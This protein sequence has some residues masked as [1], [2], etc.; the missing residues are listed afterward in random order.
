PTYREIFSYTGLD[1][2]EYGDYLVKG[3]SLLLNDDGKFTDGAELAGVAPFGWYWA[4]PF[5]DYDNDGRLDIYAA[6]GWITG[7]SHDDL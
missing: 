1:W 4:S 7:K 5:F 3:N 6:N 2:A